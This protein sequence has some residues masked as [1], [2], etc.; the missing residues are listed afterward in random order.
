MMTPKLV[1]SAQALVFPLVFMRQILL[2]AVS[3]PEGRGRKTEDPGALPINRDF[4]QQRA[5]GRDE[6]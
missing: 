4:A 5:E 2:V 3:A 1:S 6:S